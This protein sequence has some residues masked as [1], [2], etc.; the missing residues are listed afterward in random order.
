MQSMLRVNY[1]YLLRREGNMG[2]KCPKYNSVKS[3]TVLKQII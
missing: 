2:V 1:N 3:V